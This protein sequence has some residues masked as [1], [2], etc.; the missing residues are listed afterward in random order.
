[1]GD[2]SIAIVPKISRYPDRQKKA[3]EILE[4]LTR[5]GIVASELTDCTLGNKGYAMGA[6]AASIVVEPSALPLDLITNGLEIITERDIF[7]TGQLGLDVV[8]CPACNEDIAGGE[9]D[10]IDQWA[11]GESDDLRCPHCDHTA[12]IHQF[13]F[14]VS[15]GF[16]DLGFIFWNWPE[17]NP[18]FIGE[19]SNRLACELDI[20]YSKI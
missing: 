6:G 19:F 20:V 4:W 2:I 18:A 3:Q 8:E 7:H 5:A 11:S 1:M 16:S 9:L 12:E 17:F 15:W 13:N 14:D 10:F